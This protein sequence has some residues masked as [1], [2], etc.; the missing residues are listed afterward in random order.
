MTEFV[1]IASLWDLAPGKRM[2]AWIS[3]IRVML[4]NV[5]GEIYAV[6]EQCTHAQCSLLEGPLQGTVIECPCHLATFDVRTGRVLRAPATVD[7]PTYQV[8]IEGGYIW[9]E[10]KPPEIV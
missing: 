8:K 4:L 7:L 6:D 3:G 5:D 9:V 2:T 10:Q 1:R